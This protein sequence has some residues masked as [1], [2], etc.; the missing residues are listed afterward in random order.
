LVVQRSLVLLSG[1]WIT[2]SKPGEELIRMAVLRWGQRGVK[3][4][5]HDT[6]SSTEDCGSQSGGVVWEAAAPQIDSQSEPPVQAV[7]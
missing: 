5:V 1:L 7:L 4:S 6:I 3:V 2:D